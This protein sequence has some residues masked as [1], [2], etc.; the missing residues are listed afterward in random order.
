LTISE[1]ISLEKLPWRVSAFGSKLLGRQHGV[2]LGDSHPDF[3]VYSVPISK[4]Y[5]NSNQITILA[6]SSALS[7]IPENEFQ[8]TNHRFCGPIIIVSEL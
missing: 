5:L 2:E 6:S 3:G 1:I 8:P 7:L 4:F